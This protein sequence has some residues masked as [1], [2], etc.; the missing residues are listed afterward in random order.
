MV[1]LG[2]PRSRNQSSVGFKYKPP[3]LKKNAIGR[4]ALFYKYYYMFTT[5]RFHTHSLQDTYSTV[6]PNDAL[7]N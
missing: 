1:G 6:L 4:G 5:R 3:E 2:F 7:C